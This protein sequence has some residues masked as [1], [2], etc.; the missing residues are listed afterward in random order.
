LLGG[1][2]LGN[3]AG[4]IA[5]KVIKIPNKRG[6]LA[7]RTILNDFQSNTVLGESFLEYYDRQGEMYFYNY[8]K[9]LADSSNL[10][11]SD[12][13]DWG[14]EELYKTEIGVGECAGVVIDLVAT[15]LLESQEKIDN[16][17]EA[18]KLEQFS[19]SIYY[20]Y[21]SIVNTA[22]ALLLTEGKKTNTQAGIIS[23][24]EEVFGGEIKLESSFSDFVYQI[25][26]NEPTKEFAQ[27]YLNDANLFYAKVD[28]FHSKSVVNEG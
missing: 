5:D 7:L 6:P 28:A 26:K 8:L 25:Q 11:D 15:L 20:S 17:N 3:G 2:I 4:R 9:P 23:Q 13:I 12:F 16:A 19:D 22:K 1:G 21:T 10:V 14:S 18:L 27:S 24:F